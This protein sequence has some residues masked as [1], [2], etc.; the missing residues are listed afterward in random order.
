MIRG[1]KTVISRLCCLL[2]SVLITIN[3]FG[4][5]GGETDV[6]QDN[7]VKYLIGVSQA[8][9]VEPWRVV[10]NEEIRDEAEK[11]EEMRV[12]FSDAAQN[13]Q[14]QVKDVEELL[15]EGIDLLI[16]SPNE[17]A[18]L[19]PIVAE[20]YRKI[21]VI[22]LDRAVEGYDY[23]LFIG[24]DN[25]LIGRQAGKL[26]ADLIGSREGN[27]IEIQGLAGSP[28]VRDRSEG[29]RE[30][31]RQNKN[32]HVVDTIVA[33]WQRDMAED[34]LK[35]ELKKN[36][37]VDVIFAQND[38][39][40]LGAHRATVDLGLR[41]IKII[42]VDGL[43]GK[44]GGLELVKNGI[45]EGTFTCP[46][47]GREAIKYALDILTHERGIPK[48]IILRSNLVT[49]ENVDRIIVNNSEV[50]KTM[51][52]EGKKI[53]LGFAQ[54]GSESMFRLANSRSI[55]TAA[56]DAGIDLRFIN[57]LGS[58]NNQIKA[59]RSFIEQKVDVIAFSPLVETGWEEVLKEAKQAGIPVI[60]SDRLVKTKD[61]SL[62]ST[63]IGSDFVEEGRRAARW[64]VDRLKDRDSINIVE[65]RGTVGSAP[66]NDRSTGFEEVIKGNRKFEIIRSESGNFTQEEGKKV[67]KAILESEGRRINAVYAHNDDMAF[68]AIEAINAYGLRPGKDIIIVSIDGVRRAF[69]E[70]AAG[71]LNC[72]VECNPLLGPQLMKAVKDYMSGK[73]LPLRIITSE[74]VF[75]EETAKKELP[76]RKY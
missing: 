55:Q 18:A 9:L 17:S 65:L 7:Q 23:T 33:D 61:D 73:E 2:I 15:Q 3:F 46:T 24:P 41:N 48:K 27:I 72:T 1:M 8:N 74:G 5:N 52:D 67:M 53:V 75:P 31:V 25:R 76:N 6:N 37:N 10:M 47:G 44:N 70:M 29:F 57:A 59:I 49:Q 28:P 39:M 62:Y 64:L 32:I 20:A 38:H 50:K 4:C 16:I 66:A 19:T 68:G 58:Q 35:E 26:V 60:C 30:V 56:E 69:Q 54:V 21:P 36:P 71:R 43:Q 34:K 63:F 11:H 14:K 12:I 51:R 22:V 42:G 45:L 40:A 13:S